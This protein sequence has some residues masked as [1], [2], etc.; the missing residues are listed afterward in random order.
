MRTPKGLTNSPDFSTRRSPPDLLADLL[1]VIGLAGAMVLRAELAAPWA[2]ESSPSRDL[3]HILHLS[4]RRLMVMYVVTKG[5]CCL[6]LRDGIAL[7]FSEGEVVLLPY[8]DRHTVTSCESEVAPSQ[9][10]LQASWLQ[11]Q[12]PQH[13]GAGPHTGLICIYL[14]CDDPI[15]DPVVGSFA[16]V[17]E[18]Q[19]PTGAAT[20]WVM[21]SARYA[22]EATEGLWLTSPSIVL[23]LLEL[24]LLE[25]LR[26]Y[27]AS[28]PLQIGWFAALHDPIVGPALR[29]LH[30]DPAHRW[31]VEELARRSACSRSTLSERFSRLLGRAPMHY[32]NEW[33]LQTAAHLLRDTTLSAAAVAYQVGYESEEAFNRAFKRAM[34]NPP[35]QW[36]QR[37]DGFAAL[38]DRHSRAGVTRQP[39]ARAQI[40]QPLYP[41]V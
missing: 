22:A 9:S 24:L 29:E 38:V 2:Y 39:G 31:T 28:H 12:L 19:L 32:L 15:F 4:A 30:A 23:R 26:R 1:S 41:P 27:W 13:D 37:A 6:R 17:L 34:G 8:A 7:E 40:M 36:R 3:A 10:L 5:K 35:A 11:R 21:E 33:R 16:P 25:V 18:I 20:T 14:Q